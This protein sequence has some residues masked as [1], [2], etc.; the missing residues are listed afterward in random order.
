M[1]YCND[2]IRNKFKAIL[3]T[4]RIQRLNKTN[5][6]LE[7][8][9]GAVFSPAIIAR[10]VVINELNTSSGSILAEQDNED[11]AETIF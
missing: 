9:E 8:V 11:V 1:E 6:N 10:L 4:C 7:R 2:L 3:K 5:R